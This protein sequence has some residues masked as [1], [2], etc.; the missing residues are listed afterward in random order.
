MGFT[1]GYGLNSK[2]NPK[3]GCSIG[4]DVGQRGTQQAGLIKENYVNF[5]LTVTYRDLWNAKGAKFD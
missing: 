5:T 3:L 2:K 1:L 4:L